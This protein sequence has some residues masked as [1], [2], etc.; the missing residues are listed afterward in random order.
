[1]TPPAW[2]PVVL[3][4]LLIGLMLAA[5]LIYLSAGDGWR[6]TYWFAGALLNIAVTYGIR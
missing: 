2:L 4:S 1:M 3:P 5:S 6:A